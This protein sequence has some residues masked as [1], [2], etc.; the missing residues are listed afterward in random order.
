MEA[1]IHVLF[2]DNSP[3]NEESVINYSP[4]RC[5]KPIRPCFI[6]GKQIFLDEIQELSDPA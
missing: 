2:R 1:I 5:L 3:K 6:F 4:S